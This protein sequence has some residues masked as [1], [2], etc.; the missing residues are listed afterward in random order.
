[1]AT[2]IRAD[3]AK[4]RMY[5]ILE[6]S[7]GEAESKANLPMIDREVKKLG[8]GF[9]VIADT[10]SCRP[11][12]I[13]VKEDIEAVQTELLKYGMKRVIRV[14]GANAISAM[15]LDNGAKKTGY[16]GKVQVDTAATV[17]EAEKLLG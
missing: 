8:P 6:G 16:S 4:N 5:I 15:Q 14:V 3:I 17:E 7:V 11:T 10:T 12:T 9:S 1:M 13:K 2:T